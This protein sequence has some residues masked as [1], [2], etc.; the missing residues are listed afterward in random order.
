ML[1]LPRY[2]LVNIKGGGEY[3]SY[4]R[5]T[6]ILFNTITTGYVIDISI[7]HKVKLSSENILDHTYQS[8]HQPLLPITHTDKRT[9]V[10]HYVGK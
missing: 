3:F 4:K 6:S 2:L 8:L 1:H 10:F 7:K 5:S 9:S